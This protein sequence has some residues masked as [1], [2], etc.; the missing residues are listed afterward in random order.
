[1]KE[2]HNTRMI[3]NASVIAA[4]AALISGCL[5][6]EEAVTG[7]AE[8]A[9]DSEISGSVGDGPVIGAAMRIFRN[10]G[11]ELAAFESDADAG[12][13]IVIRTKGKYYPL[14]VDARSGTDIVTNTAPDFTLLG[15][16]F[17]P[18]KKTVA[19][20]NPFSTLAV[21]LARDLTGGINKANLES[22]QDTVS[23][24][25]NNGLSSLVTTGPM[26]SKID[27]SNIAEI[28][29]ASEA[30]GETVRR[31]RNA[32]SASGFST[33]GDAVVRALA[34]DLTDNVVD[35]RGGPRSDARHAA[36]STI[37]AA[38][39]ALETMANELHVNGGDATQAMGN[40]I[41]QV[42]VETADPTLV[43]LTV[44][45]EMLSRTRIGLA[46]AYAVTSDEKIKELLLLMIDVQPA[47]GSTTIR[48]LV[49]PGDYR[50]R[51]D[52][53]ILLVAG[54]NATVHETVNDIS[55]TGTLTVGGGNQAP[56]ISGSPM[57]SVVAGYGYSFTPSATDPEGAALTFAITAMPTWANFNSATGHL[58]GTPAE[59]D[60]GTYQNII[61][62]VSDGEFSTSLSAFAITVSS[63][64]TNSSP[65]ISG[66]PPTSINAGDNYTFT[67]T[68]SDPEGDTLSFS[69]SGLPSWA[70]FDA[71]NGRVSGTPQSG[72][73][74]TYANIVISV[75][76]GQLSA[77]LAP[78][79]ITVNAVSLGSVT[80]S[81]TPPTQNTDGTSL[82]DLA[83][84]KIYWGTSVGIYPNSV[85][86]NN[87]S[88]STY[89][90]ENL[91]PGTYEFVATSFNAAGVESSYSNSTTKVVQ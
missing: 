81:W 74:G 51:L 89:V 5:E 18:G 19:N 61:I 47:T 71:T 26:R 58:S 57:V 24:Q 73:V 32:I 43:D 39:V 36:V 40:A 15:A 55:R 85:T 60:V 22:A 13:N 49:L 65:Q 53:A 56:S 12:Y 75:S 20:V 82:T 23:A 4:L 48:N 83:G 46:A 35:G 88:I 68:A 91:A 38:Q 76:D 79:T 6:K 2:Q 78:F 7:N 42:S 34:S 16:A 3:R 84:Y 72:D 33:S 9:V 66:T 67:P 28:I 50:T 21:E 87:S 44:T 70:S 52:N 62:S 41:N 54:G 69:V 64:V 30:L 80:L 11:V 25:F 90:V 27:G 37:V 17:E 77:P 31:T 10:D 14:S 8:L 63:S 1:M 29:R 86:V 45:A 59:T